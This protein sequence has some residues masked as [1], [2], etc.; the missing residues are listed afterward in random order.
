MGQ[1]TLQRAPV[2]LGF[3]VQKHVLDGVGA[4]EFAQ[5]THGDAIAQIALG[6]E[7]K[8]VEDTFPRLVFIVAWE[9]TFPEIIKP[10]APIKVEV[11]VQMEDDKFAQN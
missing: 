1:Q 11:W 2:E 4:N 6:V 10:R 5:F 8:N 7:M 9:D 3:F